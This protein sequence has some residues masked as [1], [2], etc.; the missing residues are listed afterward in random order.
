M[1]TSIRIILSTI[2]AT[3][4]LAVGVAPL[5]SAET[6]SNNTSNTSNTG[7][8]STSDSREETENKEQKE[9]NSR[10]EKRKT[11]FKVKLSDTEHTR[12]K[13]RCKQAQGGGI[14]SLD[15]RIKGI[16]TS[17]E[18]VHKNLV[19]RLNKLVDKLKAKNIDTT[20]L[21]S[22]IT[23][24]EA[25]IATFKADLATY[26]QDMVDLK[27]MDCAADPTAFKAALE[28]ARADREKVHQDAK[29]IRS[30][31]KD[32][33]KPTLKEIRAQLEAEEKPETSTENNSTEGD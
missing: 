11:E 24:L 20:E 26:K 5:V 28:A 12:I 8:G 22:E 4:L 9:R 7:T 27:A 23:V 30:Y 6:D 19:N 32:T 14:K 2:L 29:D 15:G 31:V 21:E 13:S 25:K 1:K 33:I 16:E 10:L 18:R 17:R 3:P